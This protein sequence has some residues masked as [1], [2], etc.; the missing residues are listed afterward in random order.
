MNTFTKSA[1][2]VR[3]SMNEEILKDERAAQS[4]RDREFFTQENR[5]RAQ[6]IRNGI[7]YTG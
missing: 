6:L 4:L 3:Q 7:A 1:A 2:N 5:K